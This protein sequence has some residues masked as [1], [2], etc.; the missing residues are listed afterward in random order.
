MA[1]RQNNPLGISWLWFG[2]AG[3]AGYYLYMR[4]KAEGRPAGVAEAKR[5]A[6][7][8]T[9]PKQSYKYLWKY[10]GRGAD[11]DA[12]C[13]DVS[14]GQYVDDAMCEKLHG[15]AFPGRVSG[16]GNYVRV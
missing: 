6:E 12:V 13:R 8:V 2:L 10:Y 14:S 15:P 16:V 11:R 7:K 1:R 4:P 3:A 9:A 5:L